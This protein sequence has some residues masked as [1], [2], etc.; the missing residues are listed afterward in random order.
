MRE[1][2]LA[3]QTIVVT[4]ASDGIGREACRAFV[5]GGA[6]VVMIGRNEAKTAAAAKAIMSEFGVRSVAWDIADLSRLDAISALSDRLHE[7]FP[8]INVL[9]NNAGALFMSREETVDGLERTFALNH[10]AYFALTVGLLDCIAAASSVGA[11]SRILSVSSR[12]HTDARLDLNDLQYTRGYSGLRAYANSK[13]CNVLF[14]R[15]LASRLDERRVVAHALHPGVVSTR[16][17]TNNGR[18]GRILRRIMDLVSVTPGEGADTM[19]WL[20]TA[21][22]A[23]RSTGDYWVK[24]KQRSPSTAAQQRETGEALW[25]ASKELSH[26]DADAA[27]ARAGVSRPHAHE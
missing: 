18:R 15:A 8:R 7:R 6:S 16:F 23:V 25:T 1:E 4:G 21:H 11:P 2:R 12:A 24:R 9:V 20:A 22:E 26:C 19:V 5:R 17:A 3:G 27:I 13:L 14:T 10:L